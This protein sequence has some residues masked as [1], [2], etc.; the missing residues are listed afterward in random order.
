MVP[1]GRRAACAMFLPYFCNSLKSREK[2]LGITGHYID[3]SERI[4]V[5][6][7]AGENAVEFKCSGCCSSC[8][9]EKGFFFGCGEFMEISNKSW[10]APVVAVKLPFCQTISGNCSIPV[11]WEITERFGLEG[12]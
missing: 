8:S 3:L 9:D 7:P 12:A 11:K 2:P 4:P 5:E 10:K 1:E 6:H